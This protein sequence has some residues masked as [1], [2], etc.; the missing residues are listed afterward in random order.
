MG[1]VR[2]VD[3]AVTPTEGVRV[4][5][6]LSRA[7]NGCRYDRALEKANEATLAAVQQEVEGGVVG[8]EVDD[9]DLRAAL[10]E[11]LQRARRAAAT[12]GHVVGDA[13]IA[14]EV[15]ARR[16]Q[17]ETD[18]RNRVTTNDGGA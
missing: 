4:P 2:A 11:S 12:K 10:E 13:A 5:W 1:S 8:G 15:T 18:L 16:R 17:D 6:P 9:D 7:S 3:G 14:E